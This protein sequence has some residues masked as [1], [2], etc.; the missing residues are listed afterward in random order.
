MLAALAAEPAPAAVDLARPASE[1]L[2][3]VVPVARRRIARAL[4]LA[5]QAL[6]EGRIDERQANLLEVASPRASAASSGAA[7]PS[8]EDALALY[9]GVLATA[10]KDAV[11]AQGIDAV[12]A[13]LIARAQ[14]ALDREDVLDAQR[15]AGRAAMLRPQDPALVKLQP[16]LATA[17][18]V[19]GLIERG[20]RLES[21]GAFIAPRVDNAASAYRHALALNPSSDAAKAGLQR[22]EAG[23]LARALAFAHAANYDDALRQLEQAR[24]VQGGSAQIAAASASVAEIR[25]RH[26]QLLA[27]QADVALDAGDADRAVPLLRRIRQIL[28][29]SP[30][31]DRIRTRINNVRLYGRH[32]PGQV[33]TDALSAGGRSPEMVVIPVGRFEM[34]SD[35]GTPDHRS[36]EGPP[37][38]IAFTH[39]FAMSRTEI[40][41]EQFGRFVKATR[42][43]TDAERRGDSMVYVDTQG[44]LVAR[45]GVSWRDDHLGRPAAAQMPVV[46]VSWNDAQAYTIWLSSQSARLYRLPTEAEF[47]YGLRAGSQTEYP[48]PGKRPPRNVGNL[49]GADAS[50]GGRH[51]GDAFAGYADGYWGPAP[52]GKFA[53]NAFGLYDMVGNVAEWVQDCWHDSYRRA[54]DDASAWV[55]PGCKQRVVRGASWASAPAQARAAW[56]GHADATDG[57]ARV[58]FRVVREL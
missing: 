36:E 57:S 34:G 29:G 40:T 8:V 2:P 38:G 46:H 55:N 3:A 45:P 16:A 43:R 18:K 30:L 9:R 25:Q 23:F 48:W 13:A 35:E 27:A 10:P 15:D 42:Y 22:V 21:V 33:F 50:P 26:A 28:P 19:A 12:V 54:P 20:R 1:P 44:R 4:R 14:S 5:H 47:E 51:W 37:R 49:A 41:V 56:R 39:G 24:R 53:P 52:V 32:L 58:G 31:I 6:A 17:W 11:A 7:T